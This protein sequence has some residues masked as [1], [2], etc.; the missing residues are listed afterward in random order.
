[1]E[2]KE[3]VNDYGEMILELLIAEV[4]SDAFSFLVCCPNKYR[5]NLVPSAISS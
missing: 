2:C 1:M 3:I 5:Y 4:C